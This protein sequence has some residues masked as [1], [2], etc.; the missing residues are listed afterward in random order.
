MCLYP[1]NI[2]N[3]RYLPNKT[4]GGKPP[5]CK[6]ERLLRVDVPCNNCEQCMKQKARNWR[7]RLLEE[8]RLMYKKR[9]KGYMITLTFSPDWLKKLAEHPEVQKL[10]GY[11]RENRICK[12]AEQLFSNRWKKKFGV[13]PRRILVTELGHKANEEHRHTTEHV[14]MHGIIWTK[15]DLPKEL[16]KIWKYGWVYADSRGAGEGAMVYITKYIFKQDFTHKYWKPKVFATKGLGKGYMERGDVGRNKFNGEETNELYKNYK[17]YEMA[18][19]IYYRNMI[20][21]VEEREELR[22]IKEDKKIKWVDG[23]AIDVSTPEGMLNYE[24]AIQDA[25]AKSHRHGYR[26]R[27]INYEE[28]NL[29]REKRNEKFKEKI[30]MAKQSG[31]ELKNIVIKYLKDNIEWDDG[32]PK[33]EG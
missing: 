14:H 24:R 10:D 22:L 31:K 1:K 5:K 23:Q 19:P 32:T 18:L 16:A 11:N 8:Y 20:Y 2:L 29:E 25:K 26:G 3:P 9:M 6:D 12:I 21:T 27:E 33:E 15:E 7:V 30:K 13:R 17:G 4:N 28:R